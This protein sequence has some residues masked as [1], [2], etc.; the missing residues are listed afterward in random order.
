MQIIDYIFSAW[1]FPVLRVSAPLMFAALGGLWCERSGVIQIGLEG[2]MNVGAFAAACVALS[3]HNPWLGWLAGMAAGLVLASI[4]GVSVIRFKSNQIVAGMAINILAIGIPPSFSVWLFESTSSTPQLPVEATF[5]VA[6]LWILLVVVVLSAWF[7]SNGAWGLRMIFAGEHPEALE[8]S[9][10]S[11]TWKRW[12]GVWIAGILAGCAGA[13]LSL[14][15]SSSYSRSMSA[16]RG[17]IA[18][19]AL[20]L[21]RWRP[22]PTVFACLLFGVTEIL[23]TRLQGVVIWGTEPVPVQW[24]QMLPYAITI[25]VLAGF[26]GRAKAPKALGTSSA[27]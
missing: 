24:I 4:Y 17:F 14:Y 12:Q 18:L 25:F 6:P 21:G 1:F 2:F 23:Q 7:F 26:V 27:N 20:I 5:S 10:V 16:G 9:G 19:A 8:S 11:V 22:I 3:T 13:T 15:L